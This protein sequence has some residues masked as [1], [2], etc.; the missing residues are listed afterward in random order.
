MPN[1]ATVL[2]LGLPRSGTTMVA[3]VL[4]SLGLDLLC[5]EAEQQTR[6]GL[7][8]GGRSYSSAELHLALLGARLGDPGAAAQ[9]RALFEKRRGR[10]WALR[11]HAL[12]PIA[13]DVFPLLPAPCYVIE[14]VRDPATCCASLARHRGPT[15]LTWFVSEFGHPVSKLRYLCP[16]LRIPFQMRLRPA[17]LVGQICS[18]LGVAHLA[19]AE[20]MVRPEYSKFH[21]W[22]PPLPGLPDDNQGDGCCGQTQAD[23]DSVKE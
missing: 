14:P 12:N 2:V 6:P 1:P 4:E 21:D 18:F 10:L 16:W 13:M 19:E 5:G 9:L 20:Q 15:D 3:A 11:D 8:P 23:R 7:H 22:H 17:T